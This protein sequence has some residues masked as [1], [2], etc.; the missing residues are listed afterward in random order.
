MFLKKGR[1]SGNPRK[2]ELCIKGIMTMKAA[3]IIG[4]EFDSYSLR[5]I[6]PLRNENQGTLLQ[7]LKELELNDFIEI[8]NESD[9]K[10]VRCRFNKYFLRESI[11]QVMLFRDQKQVLH[12][13]YAEH[14][15]SLPTSVME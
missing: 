12:Q 5:K 11:Y 6:L 9:P 15:Q 14:L 2:Q 4:E 7:I 13:Q 3:T 8:L 1:L 10:N